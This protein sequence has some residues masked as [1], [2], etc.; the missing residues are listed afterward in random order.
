ML[1]K[2]QGLAAMTK[3]S[4]IYQNKHFLLYNVH[5]Q[6]LLRFFEEYVFDLR[7]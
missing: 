2:N 5:L 1:V 6:I 3:V 7:K 4:E